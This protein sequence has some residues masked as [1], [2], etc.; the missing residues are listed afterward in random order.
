MGMRINSNQPLKT[1]ALWMI[2]SFINLQGYKDVEHLYGQGG[3]AQTW[4]L[5]NFQITAGSCSG[6]CPD[7]TSKFDV[8]F[9]ENVFHSLSMRTM[10]NN[11]V[12]NC[13]V[14][15]K[16]VKWIRMHWKKSSLIKYLNVSWKRIYTV[17]NG[18]IRVLWNER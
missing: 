7:G 2:C 4:W 15:D 1:N 13:T 6:C 11:N 16:W 12:N 8:V 5:W 17:L 9:E 10:N 18:I 3:F 14:Y